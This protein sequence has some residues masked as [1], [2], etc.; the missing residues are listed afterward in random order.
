MLQFLKRAAGIEWGCTKS[1]VLLSLPKIWG[2]C[3]HC[4]KDSRFLNNAARELN[5]SL[6]PREIP[7]ELKRILENN[8]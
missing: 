8:P 4:G 1:M 2:S 7:D 3:F 5:L 6:K